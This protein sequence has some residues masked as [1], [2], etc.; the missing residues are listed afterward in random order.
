[1]N[2]ESDY[3]CNKN[4]AV[5]ATDMS[6]F[7]WSLQPA[8]PRTATGDERV[9]HCRAAFT[10]ACRAFVFAQYRAPGVFVKAVNGN[11]SGVANGKD[12]DAVLCRARRTM[13]PLAAGWVILYSVCS[14]TCSLSF[15]LSHVRMLLL[16]H[17]EKYTKSQ[18]SDILNSNWFKHRKVDEF[19]FK[20]C[21]S[22][23]KNIVFVLK[24]QCVCLSTRLGF[25]KQSKY[26]TD[27]SK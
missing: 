4:T 26:V 7:G 13:R 16:S 23:W 20:S 15:C 9:Q 14:I 22:M 11:N 2:R 6:A 24:K 19:I 3:S 27:T 21:Q 10:T 25:K 18:R 8:M 17:V 12:N 5:A 1:M